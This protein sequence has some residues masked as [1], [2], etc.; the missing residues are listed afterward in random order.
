MPNLKTVMN[1]ALSY[2]EESCSSSYTLNVLHFAVQQ[3]ILPWVQLR[4]HTIQSL[5]CN[6]RYDS[7][8][9]K[10]RYLDMKFGGFPK[11]KEKER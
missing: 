2:H 8:P 7:L 11:K 6:I 9:T 3:Q 4:K 10:L 1:T 5:P